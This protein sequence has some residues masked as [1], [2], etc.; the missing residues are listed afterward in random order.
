M[1]PPKD[2]Q[3]EWATFDE[4]LPD[5]DRR[6]PTPASNGERRTEGRFALYSVADERRG[7][8]GVRKRSPNAG[9]ETATRARRSSTSSTTSR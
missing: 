5:D 7:T 1:F 9:R 8:A 4:D 2:E 6:R 3:P